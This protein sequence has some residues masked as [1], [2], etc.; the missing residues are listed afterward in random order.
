M[1]KIT[2]KMNDKMIE[3]LEDFQRDLA[4]EKYQ[5]ERRI[6]VWMNIEKL[7]TQNEIIFEMVEDKRRKINGL[8]LYTLGDIKRIDYSK[9]SFIQYAYLEKNENEYS[10]TKIDH[11]INY[12][13]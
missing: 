6:T 9:A 3:I 8:Y 2:E 7:I 13:V 10:I 11:C 1:K 12:T 4:L 5:T